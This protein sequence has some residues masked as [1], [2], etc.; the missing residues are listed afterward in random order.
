MNILT[1]EDLRPAPLGKHVIADF[2][3]A[4]KLF[5]CAP[6]GAVLE[7]AAEAAGATVLGVDMHDFGDRCG[8][9]GVAV[10]AESHISIHT[11]PEH[12]YAAID[13]FMCGDADPMK[14]VA[15]LREFF[16]PAREDVQLLQRGM[17]VHAAMA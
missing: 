3:G 10:L 4:T 8:F 17:A 16:A 2:Y 5:E 6:V 11:W 12:D 1:T 9:T 13:I 7:Q 14:S 15:I